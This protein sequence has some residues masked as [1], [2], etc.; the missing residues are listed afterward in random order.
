MRR[1]SMR[2]VGWSRG[3]LLLLLILLAGGRLPGG[4]VAADPAA[5][6]APQAPLVLRG[7]D[8]PVPG[9]YT[10]EG[11]TGAHI[12]SQV[13]S[14]PTNQA[15]VVYLSAPVQAPFDFTDVAPRW[16]NPN[17]SVNS[18]PVDADAVRVE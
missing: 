17:A 9:S 12:Q 13:L 7:A 8:T 2:S 15:N 4:T 14:L 11:G 3:A 5:A 16:D 18:A 10:V 6:P 1:V